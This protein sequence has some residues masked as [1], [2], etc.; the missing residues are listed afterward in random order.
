VQRTKLDADDDVNLR[1]W[2]ERNQEASKMLGNKMRGYV[3][4]EDGTAR[5]LM[6]Q[7]VPFVRA[8]R[9]KR[10]A[11]APM[12]G[13]RYYNQADRDPGE[14][15]RWRERRDKAIG[16]AVPLAIVFVPM[17]LAVLTDN[18]AWLLGWLLIIFFL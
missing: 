11:R 4:D 9:A 17:A 7:A 15:Q 1:E 8:T 16:M 12:I 2:L 6:Q 3:I 14:L 18:G 10:G 5:I 13:K